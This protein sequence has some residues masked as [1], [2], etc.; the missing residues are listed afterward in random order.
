MK[1]KQIERGTVRRFI[2]QNP[3]LTMPQIAEGIG[4]TQ[5]T[6]RE[7]L[8]NAVRDG[9]VIRVSSPN[10]DTYAAGGANGM[11]FGCA[12]PLIM[13]FNNALKKVSDSNK[14]VCNIQ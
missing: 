6:V 9:R 2:E 5:A 3:W 4:C 11:P 12:N 10:G 7:F 8:R 14:N 1:R 13:M